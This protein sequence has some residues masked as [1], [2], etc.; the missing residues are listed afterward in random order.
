MWAKVDAGQDLSGRVLGE[1]FRLARL[2]GRGGMGDVYLAE[3]LE[4]GRTVVV[5]LLRSPAPLMGA[6]GSRRDPARKL[7]DDEQRFKRE[8]RALAQL[9]HP[10]IVQLYLFGRADDGT[11]YLAM[12]YV[13]GRTLASVIEE[14]GPVPEHAALGLLEQ[15]CDALIEAH[16]RGIVHRDLKPDNVMLVARPERAPLVKVLD[17]GIAK[18][19]HPSELRITRSG[20]LVGT[21]LY[22]APEQLRGL[23]S[24]A[25]TDIYALG[26]IAYELLTGGVPFEPATTAD[27][28]ARAVRDDLPAPSLR[29]SVS[30]ATD[31]VVL[32]CLARDP[33]R[34][35][36]SAAELRAA[37]VEA[38]SELSQP[39]A[40]STQALRLSVRPDPEPELALPRR[41]WRLRSAL[42][43]VSVLGATAG[44]GYAL[45]DGFASLAN[46][47]GSAREVSPAVEPARARELTLQDWVQGIPFPQ[48]TEYVS[49][50]PEL[51]EARVPAAPATVLAFYRAQLASK[52]GGYSDLADGIVWDSP[53]ALIETLT[54]TP[55]EAGTRLLI[56]RRTQRHE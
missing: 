46:G 36:G 39:S 5:K 20:E 28:L 25:R 1:Q 43:G 3:Q 56:T 13:P 55:L 41:R 17:F 47:T 44:V 8:A 37:L 34:R 42:V 24:D 16:A 21:P 6:G 50:E 26:L 32:R 19:A 22:M 33:E 31:L 14:Q 7:E 18:L 23:P 11:A 30:R 2:L 38:R 9:N 45:L 10:N 12:E 15:L 49:F 4:L 48:G 51:I 52:W 29:G 40:A 54:V 27:I 53:L 35:Y